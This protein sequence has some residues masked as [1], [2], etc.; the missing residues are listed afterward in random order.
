M[1]ITASAKAVASCAAIPRPATHGD[2]GAHQ[3]GS[4]QRR[5]TSDPSP[6]STAALR[7][8]ATPDVGDR[9]LGAGQGTD[10]DRHRQRGAEGDVRVAEPR[11]RRRSTAPPTASATTATLDGGE[12]GRAGEHGDAA[13]P[14]ER[15]E[16]EVAGDPAPVEDD[17]RPRSASTA[18]PIS[19]AT[20]LAGLGDEA[21]HRDGA[22]DEGDRPTG[23]TPT[24]RRCR[25]RARRRL[26]SVERRTA[27]SARIRL[28]GDADR[29]ERRRRLEGH[30]RCPRGRQHRDG[31][32][33]PV[34]ADDRQAS[35]GA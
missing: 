16:R 28:P 8:S 29:D 23:A 35:D 15:A 14:G 32:A 4:D 33:G 24:A 26:G 17:R 12:L 25:R 5:S 6:T 1:T 27:A 7:V 22:G 3:E 34:A 2:G 13:D 30:D 18:P 9:Q 10:G 21:R 31:R 11:G 20:M 19:P